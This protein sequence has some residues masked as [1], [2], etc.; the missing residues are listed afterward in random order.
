MGFW[1]ALSNWI[2]Q[3]VVVRRRSQQSYPSAMRLRGDAA[4]GYEGDMRGIYYTSVEAKAGAGC[5]CNQIDQHFMVD[6]LPLAKPCLVPFRRVRHLDPRLVAQVP[7]S[8][9]FVSQSCSR[10]V[11]GFRSPELPEF[12]LQDS[13][14]RALIVF[15]RVY[16]GV[17]LGFLGVPGFFLEI[18]GA[19]GSCRA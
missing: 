9:S 1:H 11:P 13:K 3:Y 6:I 4:Q 19:V 2:K 15:Q 14:I 7:L 18:F 17:S 12:R 5:L 16:T 10:S 8:S